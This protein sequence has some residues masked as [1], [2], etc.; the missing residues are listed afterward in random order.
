M[1]N[2]IYLTLK[3]SV[4][5]KI[6]KFKDVN[7][8][9]EVRMKDFEKLRLK[10]KN[11]IKKEVNKKAKEGKENRGLLKSISEFFSD[12]S[13]IAKKTVVKK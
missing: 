12:S 9:V 6:L 2:F 7:S 4:M 13:T 8:N 3:T 10:L 5:T 11:E 1:N